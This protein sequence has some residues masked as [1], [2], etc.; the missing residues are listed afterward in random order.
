MPVLPSQA[1]CLGLMSQISGPGS[2][3]PQWNWELEPPAAGLVCSG[4][5]ETAPGLFTSL[6]RSGSHPHLP[7]LGIFCPAPHITATD[8]FKLSNPALEGTLALASCGGRCSVNSPQG[9]KKRGSL[10]PRST[11]VPPQ[12]GG[13]PVTMLS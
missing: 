10:G 7:A 5:L 4:S 8:G 1:P 3:I 13:T 11:H 6:V 2:W 12:G 9:W